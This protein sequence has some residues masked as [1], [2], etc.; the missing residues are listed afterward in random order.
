[1]NGFSLGANAEVY[2]AETL[3]MLGGLEAAIASLMAMMAPV[4]HIC[5]DIL[6]IARKASKTT[7]RSS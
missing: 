2:D 7:K 3:A 4:I 5:L 6:S 1:M